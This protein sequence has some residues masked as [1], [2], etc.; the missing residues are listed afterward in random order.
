MLDVNETPSQLWREICRQP[1]IGA[2]LA[3]V[4]PLLRAELPLR[5]VLVRR[6]DLGR[7]QLETVAEDAL[8]PRD[9]PQHAHNDYSEAQLD[10]VLGWARQGQLLHG[11]PHASPLLNA[12]V[13]NGLRGD[14]IAG[15]L[16]NE[17]GP[18]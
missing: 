6:F 12:I 15:P 11:S 17:E 3:Q 10:S 1:E 9:L 5:A 8:D 13:P 4:V 2:A 16:V 14:V 18:E 7:R